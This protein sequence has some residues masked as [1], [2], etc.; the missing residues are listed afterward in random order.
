MSFMRGLWR[1]K[2]AVRNRSKTEGSYKEVLL[3]SRR[4]GKRPFIGGA[5]HAYNTSEPAQRDVEKKPPRT[6]VACGR[7]TPARL[8]TLLLDSNRWAK[9]L[10]RV[11]YSGHAQKR[12]HAHLEGRFPGHHGKE[13]HAH[14]PDV[15]RGTEIL[16]ARHQLRRGIQ[17][18]TAERVAQVLG[19]RVVCAN[20]SVGVR[21]SIMCV[22][23]SVCAC[24]Q[25]LPV[26]RDARACRSVNARAFVRA[27]AR[28]GRTPDH[29]TRWAATAH[30]IPEIHTSCPYIY[31]ITRED[32]SRDL[33][34][35]PRTRLHGAMYTK[36]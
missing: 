35:N 11:A 7:H 32:T 13:H 23:R 2:R 19:L 31:E 4:G 14:G 3:S 25:C 26:H 6:E 9:T 30:C 24:F 17:R 5:C 29:D 1:T 33:K 12:T 28:C 15:R 16:D 10:T 21:V 20:A 27:R 22:C 34:K 36:E 8:H 18:G